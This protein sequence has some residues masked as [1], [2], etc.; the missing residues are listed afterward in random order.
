MKGNPS[1]KEVVDILSFSYLQRLQEAFTSIVKTTVLFITHDGSCI[2]P[3]MSYFDE[4]IL[5]FKTELLDDREMLQ[6]IIEKNSSNEG[7]SFFT[8]PRS[9][10]ILVAFIP[11]FFK[12]ELLGAWMFAKYPIIEELYDNNGYYLNAK[13]IL[14]RPLSNITEDNF[15]NFASAAKNITYSVLELCQNNIEMSKVNEELC[16][17]AEL[18]EKRDRSLME[19]IHSRSNAM[20]VCD[21]HN[22]EIIVANESFGNLVSLPIEKIIG[23]SCKDILDS[24]INNFCD[25]CSK[26]D[27]LK[28]DYLST[29][30]KTRDFF[31]AKR[32]IWLRSVHQVITFGLERKVQLVSIEDVTQE[33]ILREQLE[34]MAFYDSCTGLPNSNKMSV[35]FTFF[36]DNEEFL[37]SYIVCFDLSSLQL[38]SDAYG[39]S[40][41]NDMLKEIVAWLRKKN[42][43]SNIYRLDGYEFCIFL[44]R[45]SEK[46]AK[47]VAHSINSRFDQPW[48]TMVNGNEISYVCGASVSILQI[49]LGL[50]GDYQAVEDLVARTLSSGRAEKGIFFY[51][52]KKDEK[53]REHTELVIS[54][55]E[56]VNKGMKGFSLQYQPIVDLAS[57]KWV[58]LEALC[59][60][61]RP[62]CGPVS[63]LVFIPE[64]ESLGIITRIGAWVLDAA[65]RQAKRL[66][67]DAFENFFVSVN[68][69]PIQ[70]MGEAFADIVANTL[71]KYNY[72]GG[73]LNLEITENAQMTFNNFTMA[74]I[75]ELR[76]MGV[77]MALDDFGTGYSSFNNLKHLPVDF[78]K[79]ERDFIKGIEHDGYMQYFL[80]IMSELAHANKMKLIAEGIETID[81]LQKAKNNGVDYIQGYFFSKPLTAA[82]LESKLDYFSV[83]DGSYTPTTTEAINIKQWLNGKS[84]Y[85]LTPS[86]FNLMNQCMQIMLSETDAASAFR[87]VFELVGEHFRVSRVYAFVREED[88]LYSNLYEWCGEKVVSQKDILQKIP[89]LTNTPSLFTSF[90]KDGMVIASD[91]SSLENDMQAVLKGQDLS[92]VAILPMWD[93][94]DLI[95]FVGFDNVTFHSWSPEEV[96]MLWNLAMLIANTVKRE[97]LKF[98]IVEKKSILETVLQRSAFKAYVTDLETNEILWINDNMKRARM[99]DSD[100]DVV[101]QKC[102]EVLGK[103]PTRCSFCQIQNLENNLSEDHIVHEF[104]CDYHDRDYMAFASIIQWTGNK[105]SHIHYIIDVTN[106]KSTQ[107]QLEYLASTDVLTG[108]FNRTAILEKFQ[109]MIQESRISDTSLALSYVSIDRLT[110][111]NE[112][113]GNEIGD[114]VLFHLVQAIRSCTNRS[115]MI[116][117]FAGDEFLVLMPHCAKGMARVR[118][119]QARNMLAQTN[120]LANGSAISFSFGVVDVTDLS[121]TENSTHFSKLI[122]LAKSRMREQKQAMRNLDAYKP[123]LLM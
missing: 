59:R 119:M 77:K 16:D 35:D 122:S 120:S 14:F 47:R 87:N 51:D 8:Y 31:H 11:I 85:E 19:H 18:L 33:H 118:M 93:E 4:N 81:Q 80:Y 97:K 91:I 94:E 21:Y 13:N 1:V 54:L 64:A 83:P 40:M 96:I 37:E 30:P 73:K 75:T 112:R 58:G 100:A 101:G 72:P 86:L 123:R 65:V 106:Q 23:K 60:W 116:G 67:L 90:V 22:N 113:Y 76:A 38:F 6:Q 105:K 98:E 66:R 102:H 115:D 2:A 104:H 111:I 28:Q 57:G 99:I 43:T 103:N 53:H 36:I 29:R 15:T 24:S 46:N 70:M 62:G 44:G 39:K 74:V 20:Y 41:T 55:K 32:N 92:A 61:T 7:Q 114:Q 108:A 27:F 68:I 63:P 95:G 50:Q 25:L 89:V 121:H 69:S 78:L 10:G 45:V 42:F 79:T 82:E 71:K 84:A 34:I 52:Q 110:E 49:P 3:S 12:N 5:P 117:R 48:H 107:K 109:L 88:G 26:E 9:D 17:I 56:C